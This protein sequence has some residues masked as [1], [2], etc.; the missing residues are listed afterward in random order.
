MAEEVQGRMRRVMCAGSLRCP[1]EGIPISQTHSPPC[2][3]PTRQGDALCLPGVGVLPGCP[4][5]GVPSSPHCSGDVGQAGPA[6]PSRVLSL[7]PWKESWPGA[8]GLQ[9]RSPLNFS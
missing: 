7:V 9:C 4:L 1:G 6:P 3:A 8:E 5:S 2:P